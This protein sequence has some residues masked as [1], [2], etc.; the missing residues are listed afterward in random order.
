MDTGL[1]RVKRKNL[2]TLSI[3]RPVAWVRWVREGDGFAKA[4]VKPA[5]RTCSSPC[6]G[7]VE[8]LNVSVASGLC[9]FEA[10]RQRGR[11][12]A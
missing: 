7:T 2:S 9:L 1:P 11:L 6:N 10:R 4:D 5:R 12:N 8:V 3:K